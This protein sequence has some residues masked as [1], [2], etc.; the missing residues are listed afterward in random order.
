MIRIDYYINAV[1]ERSHFHLNRKGSVIADVKLEFSS[2]QKI[3]SV[4]RSQ[5]MDSQKRAHR[6]IRSTTGTN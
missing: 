3:T 4:L 2:T 5:R 1:T 6:Q